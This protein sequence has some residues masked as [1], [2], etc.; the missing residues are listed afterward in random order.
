MY[1]MPILF[2]YPKKENNEYFETSEYVDLFDNLDE[3][4]Y[5]PSIIEYACEAMKL[6]VMNK[7]RERE[8]K[9]K[10]VTFFK[11]VDEFED[12]VFNA[13]T[14]L[15]SDIS[16]ERIGSLSSES[17]SLTRMFLTLMVE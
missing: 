17:R 16:D 3:A 1:S 8:L 7:Y 11:S 9:E 2:Y 6:V 12:T 4:D 13:R 10:G 14:H 15:L 5:I